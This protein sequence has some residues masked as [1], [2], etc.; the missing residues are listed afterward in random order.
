[1]RINAFRVWIGI[2]DEGEIGQTDG[3]RPVSSCMH[4]REDNAGGELKE[5]DC[6]EGLSR[7]IPRRRPIDAAPR[8]LLENF[9]TACKIDVI[10]LPVIYEWAQ[11]H[12]RMQPDS[13]REKN[14]NVFPFELRC[15]RRE[16]PARSRYFPE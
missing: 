14:K 10:G 1:V 12:A 5:I 9:L 6:H 11:T 3:A 15:I 13:Q 8:V 2:R 4:S 7:G 16:R